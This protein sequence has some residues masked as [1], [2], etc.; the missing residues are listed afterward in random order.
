M[1][2]HICHMYL[3]MHIQYAFL[4]GVWRYV[5]VVAFG[6]VLND[7]RSKTWVGI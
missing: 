1:T 7:T 2:C 4:C 5:A 6:F 3:H